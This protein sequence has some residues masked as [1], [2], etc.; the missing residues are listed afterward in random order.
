VKVCLLCCDVSCL[1]MKSVAGNS[2]FDLHNRF[3]LMLV[4][5]DEVMMTNN[6]LRAAQ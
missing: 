3:A 1:G 2:P 6:S 4:E 5:S